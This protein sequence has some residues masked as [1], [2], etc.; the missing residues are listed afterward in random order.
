MSTIYENPFNIHLVEVQTHISLTSNICDK[1]FLFTIMCFHLHINK[2][3]F[4][5]ILIW[6]PTIFLINE[7]ERP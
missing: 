3:D 5:S 6:F 2:K 4:F 1:S 7:I